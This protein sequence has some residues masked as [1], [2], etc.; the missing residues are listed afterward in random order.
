ME[1]VIIPVVLFGSIFGIVYVY[2]ITRNKERMAMIEKG[3][4]MSL[5]ARKRGDDSP[6]KYWVIKIGFLMIGIALGII[7]GSL[8]SSDGGVMSEDQAYPSMILLF[9]GMAL[10]ASY[11]VEKKLREKAEKISD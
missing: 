7:V 11:F 10:V 5:F 6:M 9:G 3:T 2:L 4:D 8:V 1:E